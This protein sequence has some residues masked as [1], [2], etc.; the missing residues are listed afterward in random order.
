MT[1]MDRTAYPRLPIRLSKTE[2]EDLYTPTADEIAFVSQPGRGDAPRLTRLVLLKTFQHLGYFPRLEDIPEP[3]VQHLRTVLQ[4]PPA[5]QLTAG[6]ATSRYRHH[7]AI[8]EYLNVTRYGDGGEAVAVA[9][10]QQAAQTMNDPADLINAALEELIRR[11]FELPGFST[12]D[13]LT[14]SI[15]TTVNDSWYNPVLGRLTPEERRVLDQLPT[16]QDEQSRTDFVVL[17]QPPGRP[18]LTEMRRLKDRLR[19]LSSLA[20]TQR[21]LAGIPAARVKL[22]A[23]EARSL[24]TDHLRDVSTARRYTLLLCLL[25]QAKVQTRDHLVEIFLNRM[26]RVHQRAKEELDEIREKQRQL[27]EQLIQVLAQVAHQTSVTP[28][29]LILGQDVRALMDQHGG[30]QHLLR[31]C[32]ALAVY[33]D[34]NTLPLL[35]SHYANHH[36]TVFELFD[37]LE[38]RTTSEDHTLLDA[39]ALLREHPNADRLPPDVSLDFG[40]LRWQRHVLERDA[41]GQRW[42]NRRQFELCVLTCL[43]NDLK[44]GD[45][46]VLGC[47]QYADYREQLLNWE[48]CEPLV[49]AYCQ[50]V[51]IPATPDALANELHDRLEETARAVD[52]R[53]P[54][55]GQLRLNKEGELVLKRLRQRPAPPGT[56]QLKR[57]IR[58]RMPQRNLLDVL[59]FAEHWVHYTRHFGPLSGSDPKLAD[60]LARYIMTVFSYGC[61]LGPVQAARHSRGLFTARM[62][63]HVNRQHIATHHLEAASRDLINYYARFDLPHFWGSGQAAAADGTLFSTYLN[64]LLAAR[65]IRYGAYGGIAYHHVS[66]TYIALFSHF[67]AVGMWEAVYI[68]DGLLENTSDIQP[69]TLHADT[70]GQSLTVFGLT[71]LLGI[72]LMPRIRHWQ[73]L[74]LHRPDAETVYE[75]IDDL[76]DDPIDWALLIT[77]WKDLLRVVLSIQQGVLLPSMLLRK[78]GNFSRRN[79]LY[80]AFRELGRVV[81]TLFLL[82]YVSDEA[83]RRRITA[84]TTIIES[85]HNFIEWLF[86]GGHGIIQHND[87]LEQE[88]RIKYNDLVA[89]A[90]IVMNVVDLTRI[91]RQLDPNQY[92]ITRQTLA[93]LSPYQTEHIQRFGDYVIDLHTLPQAPE[94]LLPIQEDIDA[95]PAESTKPH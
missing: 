30:A 61:N 50:G 49:E 91:L 32:Q 33:H 22:F 37:L 71:Y 88:K 42:F 84:T 8:H 29:D 21:L 65:H 16:L 1:A 57:A 38:L 95:N 51:G 23:A 92:V 90:L 56:A 72:K 31:Q 73:D 14:Q 36:K 69:D 18:R 11:R 76:F 48:V 25:H 3:I 35:W 80:R 87:P 86:F 53:F 54:D 55:D 15:R 24:E 4:L 85:Y 64:N 62:L 81:R 94:L 89:N 13:R 82:L 6:A 27:T 75:H 67:I 9:A 60:P 58:E 59:A 41:D 39:L 83:L 7:A 43:A 5:V 40:S 70:H 63:S 45:V 66:D 12:L 19:W 68:I 17:K 77:H 10:I 46:C 47:E 26:Q 2:V 44:S 74:T 34:D 52:A 93:R 20:D 79:R 28:V 78:L